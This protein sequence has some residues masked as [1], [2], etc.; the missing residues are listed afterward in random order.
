MTELPAPIDLDRGPAQPRRGTR[1]RHS[2]ADIA[3]RLNERIADLARE[4]LGEPNRTLSNASQLRYGSKGSIAVEIGG[5]DAGR[6][7][8]HEQGVGGDGLELIR[9]RRNVG[10]GEACDWART[11]LGLEAAAAPAAERP[12]PASGPA[13]QRAAK[14][15]EIVA[16]SEGIAGTRVEAYLRRR[17]ITVA[18]PD[19]IRFRR[20]AAGPNGQY[21]ALVA[22]ATDADG[23]VLAVQQIYLTEEGKKAPLDVVKRTNKAVDG[24]SERSAVRLPG[25]QPIV[26]CE[27]VETALSIWQVTGRETWAT[28]GIGNIGRAPLPELATVVIARDGD[29]PGSRADA[30]VAKAAFSLQKRGHTVLMATP[31]EGQDV[32]DVLLRAGADAVRTLIDGAEPFDPP[33]D[34]GER[35]RLGVGSDV[36]IAKRVRED[37][38]ERYGRI[39]HAEGAFWH[40]ATTHWEPI[41]DHAL[42]LFVHIYDGASF[43]TPAGEPSRV[44]LSKSRI[45]SAINECASLCADPTFFET[46]PVG[47]NCASGFIRF[48][49]DGTPEIEPHS[50]EH[51][52]RHTLPGRWHAGAPGFPPEGT[53]LRR[54]L[55]G[56]F[57]GD[58]E[59]DEKVVLLSEICGSAALGY[60]TRL[61]QPRAV[62]L[63]GRTAENGK[64]QI[65]DLAR[66][67]L[68]ASA[69]CS[70]PAA[71][72][73]DERHIIGLVGKLLNATDE[74]SAAAIASDT[75]KSVVTGEPVEGR[76]VYKSRVEFRSV[77]QNLFATNK[78]P[79]FQGGLD[80]GVQRRLLVVP[81][82]RTIPIGERIT[83]IGKRIAADEPDLLLTWAVDGASR[84][85]RQGNFTIPASCREALADWI[86]AADPVLA[87]LNECTE[88]EAIVHDHP[89]IA[90]R[91]AHDQFRAWAIAEGFRANKLPAING[92]VQRVQANAAGVQYKRNKAGRFL[93]GLVV[94][95]TAPP[96]PPDW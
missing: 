90:T 36:E 89:S 91:T 12:A 31:P 27:G 46:R 54:L 82:N 16:R 44:K 1:G 37:L 9:N 41:P 17:G 62:I 47:I 59:A 95:R 23:A 19:C 76:D 20:F 75:F 39:V 49:A 48:A 33:E 13:E 40:F 66:G 74:L 85:V 56:I 24:W 38:T 77:A 6:W 2:V 51:R 84:L 50:P 11:W 14:V 35:R 53:L 26:L 81:F 92:F 60:A 55:D 10:N 63:H 68:P 73:G 34:V 70:V 67:L 65:L 15:A 29:P 32:N 8:D 3:A 25:A 42:R 79:P 83:M 5:P 88:V 52:C 71:R 86:L 96:L 69:I 28:L 61:M 58:A 45:D 64:S 21:G 43:Q 72:M 18:P 87:W 22:L 4:L 78:L 57:H 93:L 30:Q 7:Y 80:R 94:M